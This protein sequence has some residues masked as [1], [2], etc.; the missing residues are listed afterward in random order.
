MSNA[1]FWSTA[2]RAVRIPFA[3]SIVAPPERALQVLVFGEAAQ[4][5]RERALQL[6]GWV[7]AIDDV[8]EDAA[9]RGLVGVLGILCREER[10]HRTRSVSDDLRDRLERVLRARAEPD[11]RDVWVLASGR[12]PDVPDVDLACNHLVAEPGDH[13]GELL[14]PIPPL[15]R[16]QHP[17]MW[18]LVARHRGRSGSAIGALDF[19]GTAQ[20]RPS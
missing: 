5:D 2:C 17:K 12:R 13:L 15:V 20:A 18:S 6:L 9:R 10:D 3:C 19:A 4:R 14:E 11:E 16:D 7:A 1:F 8:G